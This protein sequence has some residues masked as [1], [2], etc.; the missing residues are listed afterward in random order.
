MRVNNTPLFFKSH[1]FIYKIPSRARVEGYLRGKRLLSHA[2]DRSP[3][4]RGKKA[5]RSEI[6]FQMHTLCFLRAAP[7]GSRLLLLVFRVS[8]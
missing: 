4:D 3:V 8:V 7:H 2:Q 1:Y 6:Y 5:I